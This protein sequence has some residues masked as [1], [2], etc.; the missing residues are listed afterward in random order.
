MGY[1]L[2]GHPRIESMWQKYWKVKAESQRYVVRRLSWGSSSHLAPRQ[3]QPG[4]LLVQIAHLHE[5]SIFIIFSLYNDTR[6]KLKLVESF[7]PS[8]PKASF[9]I[10]EMPRP[11]NT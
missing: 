1:F 3:A 5:V 11:G 8:I 2:L 6:K 4:L 10:Q 9:G 7:L